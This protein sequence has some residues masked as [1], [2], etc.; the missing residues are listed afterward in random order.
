MNPLSIIKLVSVAVIAL[1]IGGLVWK[2]TNLVHDN[3]T[4]KS[5]KVRLEQSIAAQAALVDRYASAVKDYQAAQEKIAKDIA[6][7]NKVSAAARDAAQELNQTFASHQL[8]QLAK[9]KPKLIEQR[10][11]SGSEKLRRDIECVTNPVC[12][13]PF[14]NIPK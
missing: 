1:V 2:Y 10:I 11:N 9:R 8:D 5:D 4:L 14:G 6:D 13:K 3:A 7:M 12:T